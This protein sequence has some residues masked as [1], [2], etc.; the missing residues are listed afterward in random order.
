M[1]N[2]NCNLTPPDEVF[3]KLCLDRLKFFLGLMTIAIIQLQSYWTT[4]YSYL[5]IF[6][7][8]IQQCPHQKLLNF[9][10][11]IFLST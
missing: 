1:K 9:F 2:F 8:A 11:N 6:M 4:R 3:K 7:H 10:N 5:L